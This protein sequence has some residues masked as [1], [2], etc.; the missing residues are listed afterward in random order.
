MKLIPKLDRVIVRRESMKKEAGL[1][2]VP[3]NIEARNRPARGVIL[4][5]GP[6][7][8]YIDEAT[9]KLERGLAVGMKV[10]F[11]RN[12]GTEIEYEGEKVWVIADR[13]VLAEI[14]DE[15]VT[16]AQEAA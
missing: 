13:D 6:T 12:A 16:Q 8:G 14:Q 3:E 2:F 1:V 10:I 5:L 7:C 9:G 11:G 4:A 15:A